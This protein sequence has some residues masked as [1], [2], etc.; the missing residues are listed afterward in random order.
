MAKPVTYP[1]IG[2]TLRAALERKG[3]SIGQLNQKLGK[4][5][6]RATVY[7]WLN[8]YT[9]PRLGIRTKLAKLLDLDPAQLAPRQNGELVEAMPLRVTGGAHVAASRNHS[10]PL[11]SLTPGAD[12]QARIQL[13]WTGPRERVLA[14]A[15]AIMDLSSEEP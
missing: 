1:E 14:M 3:W 2:A 7:S 12:G 4:S 11:F 15:R 13:D 9:A 10:D 8:G 5:R 6:S